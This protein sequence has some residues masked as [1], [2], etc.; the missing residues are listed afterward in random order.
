MNQNEIA[1][2]FI[3]KLHVPA[4]DA[5][6]LASIARFTSFKSGATLFSQGEFLD[7]FYVI[8]NGISY[9]YYTH[10]DG[11]EKVKRFAVTGEA[12]AP[13]IS[14]LRNEPSEY[15]AKAL[16]E[17]VCIELSYKDYMSLVNTSWTLEKLHRKQLEFHILE[18]EKK[19]YELFMLSAEERY[20]AFVT[21]HR[22]FLE[23]IPQKIIASYIN[24]DPATLSRIKKLG[25]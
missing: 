23:D 21:R 16:K 24:V 6:R 11:F 12:I 4:E 7:R 20:R 18:R 25:T 9:L 3:F 10:V 2:F 13:Y 14:L 5:N 15:S 22:P 8:L 1:D 19:E 17:C